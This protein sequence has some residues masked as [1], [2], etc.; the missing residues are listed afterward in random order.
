MLYEPEAFEP[1]TDEPWDAGRVRDAIGAI[2]ADADAAFDADRLWPAHE[3]DGWQ[4][5][6]PMKNL[7]VG[8]SGVVWALDALR[9]RGLAETRVDLAAAARGALELWREAPDFMEGEEVPG[10]PRPALL[11]GE[12][13]PLLV[14]CLLGAEG[15]LADDLLA[16]VRANV[17]NPTVDV[18]WGAPGTLLAAL[19]MHEH[20]GEE[21]WLEAARESA[22]AIRADR[23]ADGLWTQVEGYR[24]LGPVHGLVGNVLVLLRL[25]PDD[26]LTRRSAAV[27]ARYAYREDGLVSW[28]GSA[29][30]Q[31]AARDGAIRLQWCSG[32]PG[33]V[34][35]AGPYLD[36]ELLLAGAELVWRAGAHG[37]EKG[38]GI[39]H[40]T[41]G[42]GY[43]LLATF[44][45]TG[46]ERWLERARRFAV[47]A[48]GQLERQ[49][50]E[51]GHG[52]FSLW[53][54]DVGTA[55]FAADCLDGVP[56]YPVLER[57]DRAAK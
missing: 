22:D 15:S 24:G 48:L 37:D 29:R 50:A 42:N 17:R 38:H 31:L 47:H 33:I 23:D 20:T 9:R 21:R 16:G 32:A 55:L 36:E 27:L 1:L 19:A 5:P 43:A 6:H 4:A 40:G 53:T 41:A 35:T 18:M 34:A 54:G 14:A 28:P 12:T 39:C 2:V 3:W 25:G 51:R 26:A 49:R 52:R 10:P 44:A 56:R 7:Y 30:A 11:R 46:H 13:G 8:A 57:Q 45:R